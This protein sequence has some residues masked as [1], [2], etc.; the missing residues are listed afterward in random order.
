MEIHTEIKEKLDLFLENNNVPHILFY[1]PHGS[2]KKTLLMDFIKKMYVD[3]DEYQK[4]VMFINCALG[5]G[6]QFIR[7]D[8]KQFAKSRV[9]SK[10]K[11]K[12]IIL[13][14]GDRLTVDAQSALRR[15]IELFSETT[16]FFM[17]VQNKQ[18]LL[19]PILSRFCDIYIYY[20]IIDGCSINLHTY[21]RNQHENDKENKSYKT[22]I[23]NRLNQFNRI[24]LKHTNTD[25]DADADVKNIFKLANE[26]YDKG[27]SGY[28]IAYYYKSTHDLK[29]LYH[30]VKQYY[31]N[32]KLLMVY[33]LECLFRNKED[34]E[35]F[36]LIT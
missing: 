35:I 25:A 7:N 22:F 24:L 11:F 12:S 17:V 23:K 33:L 30:S 5:K 29:I 3:Q 13:Y 34:L 27:Y 6:I 36:E 15:S 1:G 31:K 28:D 19:R 20:P 16:R 21:K 8:I 32:E 26:L 2:G 18:Q 10:N 14:N 9:F 4:N